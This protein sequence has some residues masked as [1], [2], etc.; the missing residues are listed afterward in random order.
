MRILTRP[1]PVPRDD[2]P[3][4]SLRELYAY[5]CDLT[6]QVDHALGVLSRRTGEQQ[7]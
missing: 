7:G 5:L 1:V 2:D 3:A 4:G 6:E